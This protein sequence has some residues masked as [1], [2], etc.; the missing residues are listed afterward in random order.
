MNK[1]Y[2]DTVDESDDVY[3]GAE[4]RNYFRYDAFV[5]KLGNVR[6]LENN[7][8]FDASGYKRR[9]GFGMETRLKFIFEQIASVARTVDKFFFE[10]IA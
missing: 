10:Q 6:D 7:R 5:N 1:T 4:I 3:K 9:N 2:V 8:S